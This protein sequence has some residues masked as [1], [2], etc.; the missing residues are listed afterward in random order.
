MASGSAVLGRV[1]TWAGAVR[2]TDW[3]A[4]YAEQLPRVYNFFRYRVGPD[5]AED[6]TSIT[7]ERA[8]RAR[9]RYDRNVAGFSTWLFA[10]ARNVA[11]DH[12][13]RRKPDV[14]LDAAA[15][16]AAQ[17]TAADAAERASDEARLAR[18]LAA[19]PERS[20]ELIALK[21]GAGL[22]NRAIAREMSLSESNVGTILHRTIQDLRAGWDGGT[23]DEQR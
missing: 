4:L 18:L 16:V 10:I 15:E 1:L 11:V 23:E 20:R 19:L 12:A 17:G 8:W 13:R 22:T 9:E 2:A 3:D 14:P 6:L 5:A 7:F 21:Y